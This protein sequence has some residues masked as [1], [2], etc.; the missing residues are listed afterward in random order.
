MRLLSENLVLTMTIVYFAIVLPFAP[1]IASPDNLL[2]LALNVLPLFI[3]ALGQTCVLITGGIDLSVTSVISFV[4][5]LGALVM[6]GDDGLLAASVFATPAGIA[7]MLAAGAGIGCFNGLAIS[8]L[9]M[10]PFLVTL[11]SMIFIAGLAEW[12]TRAESIGALPD[13][14]VYLGY[15]TILFVPVSVLIA[16]AAGVAVHFLLA[17]TVVGRW[18]Y[19]VGHSRR[20]AL[21]SGVPIGR[22]LVLAY[23]ASGACAA[24]AAVL[25]TA[26]LETGSPVL[27]ERLLLDVIGAVIIG[28]TS[29]FGGHGKVRWTLYGVLFIT[30]VSNSLTAL[31][32]S[33]ARVTISK[34]LL[35]LA[36]ALLDAWRKGR[37]SLGDRRGGS[38]R[39]RS[40]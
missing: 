13:S 38:A 35:I 12:M 15:G 34:G 26:R 10:P 29:L 2:D 21:A 31:D 18:F 17:R 14:F 9:A 27:G 19:A 5:V 24:L 33:F 20:T 36:A 7:I 32:L 30:V 3:A 4:S 8:R 1:E 16:G 40:K 22:A 39:D 23:T 11:S 6:T 25:Y 37:S 28:G